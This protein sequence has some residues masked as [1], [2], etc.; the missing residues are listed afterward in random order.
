MFMK[1]TFLPLCFLLIRCVLAQEPTQAA[2][3]PG[4][5]A[6]TNDAIIKMVKAGLG[7]DVIISM[8]HT[9]PANYTLTPEELIALKSAGV[10]DRIVAAM[11]TKYSAT[12]VSTMFGGKPTGATPT[13]GTV[14]AGDAN[15]PMASHDSGIYLYAKNRNGEYTLTILEQAAYQGARTGSVVGSAFT[16]GLKKIKMKAVIPG[17][18]AGTVLPNP[19]P[20]FY[21]Y[22]E[23]K[24]A[25]LG[26]GVFGAGKVS[27]PNQFA[28]LKLEVTK[29]SRETIIG[30]FGTLGSSSGT[31][32]KSMVSFR[33]E[34]LKPG[35]YKV[36]P[37]GPMKPGE[38]C[39]LASS[40]LFGAFGAG[41]SGAN[42]IFDFSVAASK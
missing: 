15:D 31:N 16:Y 34:R 21:F 36:V 9:Q 42:Q 20:V 3:A 13:A 19:E 17:P 40:P 24:A 28:L 35:L 7:E 23:D 41:A 12:G 32:Q 33:S 5:S 18:H 25:G 30:E 6:L 37:N 4:Q 10:P 14:S 38:Y 1:Q 39:F 22:F 11:V 2:V 8:V 26:A 27:N 29:S